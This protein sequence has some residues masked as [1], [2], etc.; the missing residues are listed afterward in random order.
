[1]LIIDSMWV[2][3]RTT[4]DDEKNAGKLKAILVLPGDQD[5]GKEEVPC[6]SPTMDRNIIKLM[7]AV[8]AN[9]GWEMRSID[10]SA[11]FLQGRQID[12]DVYIRPPREL[13]GNSRRVFM[14]SRRL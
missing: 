3:Q 6:D 1:M 11:A 9:K 14:D 12:R 5:H 13:N 4:K 2:V 8:A 10:I 7:I